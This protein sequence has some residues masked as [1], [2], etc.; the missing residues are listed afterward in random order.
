MPVLGIVFWILLW[1]TVAPLLLVFVANNM[2]NNRDAIATLTL[3][4]ASITIFFSV[5]I[6]GL[7]IRVLLNLIAFFFTEFA[8]T[9]KRVLAKMGSLR[10]KSVELFLAKVEGIMVDQSAL[11]RLLGYGTLIVT[12]TGGMKTPFPTIAH[13]NEFRQQV[14]GHIV[15]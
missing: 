14:R 11:G 10:Q 9:D 6:F 2:S 7:A 8:V 3:I 4:N 13:A 1:F 12:G 5:V 15:T